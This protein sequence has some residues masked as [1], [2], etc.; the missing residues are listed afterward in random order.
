[1]AIVYP[2]Q[3]FGSFKL[4]MGFNFRFIHSKFGFD[5]GERFHKDPDYRIGTTQEIDRC[6]FD[7]YGEIGL[8]FE[9]PDPRPSV[10]PFGHRFIP[11][12]YGCQCHF[13]N[14]AEPWVEGKFYTEDDILTLKEWSWEDFKKSIPVLE[15]VYQAEYLHK[16]YGY[17]SSLPNLGSTINTAISLRSNQLFVDY[18]ENPDLVRKLYRN[19]TDLMIMTV[20]HFEKID[21]RPESN[22]FLGNCTVAMISPN[23]YQNVNME[24][25]IDYINYAKKKGAIFCIHQDSNVTPHIKNYAKLPHVSILDI[26]MDTDFEL[27]SEYFPN[28]EVNCIWFPQWIISHTSSEIE[29][30]VERLMKIGTKFKNFSFTFC[31]IDELIAEE[32]IFAF[33]ESVERYAGKFYQ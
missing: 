21:G 16:K 6:I 11:A 18:I 28:A 9:N 27:L 22:L 24:F 33:S 15:T 32:K 30:E 5:L 14:D 1:M 4:G 29:A 23:N 10:E 31:E 8:G 7:L 3:S 17:F 19:I 20:E 26:G 13:A 12:M 2:A 25:D